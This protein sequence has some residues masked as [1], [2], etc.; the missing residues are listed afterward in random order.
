M[1]ST[2]NFTTAMHRLA[3]SLSW[4]VESNGGT[5]RVTKHPIL[6][7]PDPVN[8]QQA[9]PII[10]L[11]NRFKGLTFKSISL[12]ALMTRVAM[13]PVRFGG[14]GLTA[15]DIRSRI[16]LHVS[17]DRDGSLS[18]PSDISATDETTLYRLFTGD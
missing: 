6:Y 4:H 9:E 7:I 5:W 16:A 18:L 3:D 17:R 14:L 1:R 12:L 2:T 11:V 10:N 15:E 13:S 8:D